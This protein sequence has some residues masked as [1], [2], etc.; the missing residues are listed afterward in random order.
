[1]RY[2]PMIPGITMTGRKVEITVAAPCSGTLVIVDALPESLLIVSSPENDAGPVGENDTLKLIWPPGGILAWNG[3]T[4]NGLCVDRS[5][6][7]SGLVPGFL[8]VGATVLVD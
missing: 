5:R 6:I 2:V 4:E 1:M 8:M 3:A 7:A